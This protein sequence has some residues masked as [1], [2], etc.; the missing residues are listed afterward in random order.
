MLEITRRSALGVMLGT[1][2]SFVLPGQR[3]RIDLMQFVG[4]QRPKYDLRLPFHVADDCFATDGHIC[5]KVEPD[6]GDKVQHSGKVPPF[7]SLSWNHGQLRGWRDMPALPAIMAD[8]SPCPNCHGYGHTPEVVPHECECCGGT[9][10]ELVGSEWDISHPITCRACRGR[11]HTLPEGCVTCQ[12]CAGKGDGRFPS[13]V[14][15]DGSYFDS[16]LYEKAR[17]LGGEFVLDNWKGIPGAP[18]VKFRFDGG[19]GMLMGIER[20]AAERRISS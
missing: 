14:R 11:G 4:E 10:Y 19:D 5:V 20:G 13:I 2:A 16:A 9:G 7:H 3:K 15:V 12:T 8:D 1:V 17:R 6:S 18:L